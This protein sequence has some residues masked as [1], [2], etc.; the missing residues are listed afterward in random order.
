MANLIDK[1]DIQAIRQERRALHNKLKYTRFMD[2]R[3]FENIS[4]IMHSKD[5][6]I[7]DYENMNTP[8]RVRPI[9]D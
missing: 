9:K 1:T 8:Q 3:L 2:V 7:R 4:S 6:K 5:K